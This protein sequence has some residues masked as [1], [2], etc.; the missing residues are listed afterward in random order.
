MN[1]NIISI[2]YILYDIC[3][4]KNKLFY[5]CTFSYI[6]VCVRVCVYD[7][8][9]YVA[10]GQSSLPFLLHEPSPGMC[11]PLTSPEE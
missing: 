3:L 1:I 11:D 4:Y 6:C 5:F 9:F 7:V 8:C 10:T 2:R